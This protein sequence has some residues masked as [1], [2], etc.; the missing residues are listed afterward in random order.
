[1]N[2]FFNPTRFSRLLDAHWAEKRREYVW[3]FAVLAM[4]DLIFMVIFL[5][6]GHHALLRQFQLSGQV[7][8]YMLGLLF[9]G[10]IFA[11]RY[12]KYQLNPGASLIALM[13]PASV[14]E[15]W[16]MAFLV[17]SIFYPLAYTLLYM[18]L[19]YPAVMLAKAVVKMSSCETCLYDFRLYFPFLT[20]DLVVDGTGNARPI[21]NEQMLFFMTLSAA[22]AFIAAGTAYFKRSPVLRTLLVLFLLFVLSIWT[23]TSPQLGIFASVSDEAVHYSMMEYLLSLGLWLGVPVLLWAALYF[24]IK[25][26]EIA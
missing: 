22:Q 26:R 5:G 12:F 10:L 14:F 19:N 23:E 8:W 11:G 6:T 24:F 9:S 2:N 4:L 13:R 18:L 21:L 20:T 3:F 1:M 15:K 25:E 17:I 16:L 7:F